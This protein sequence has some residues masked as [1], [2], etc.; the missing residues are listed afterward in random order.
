MAKSSFR[1]TGR[2]RHLVAPSL[3]TAVAAAAVAVW[4]HID[5]ADRRAELMRAAQARAAADVEQTVGRVGETLGSLVPLGLT[6]AESL[7]SGSRSPASLVEEMGAML[8]D[9]PQVY[10]VGLASEP[11]AIDPGTE[12]FS[13][14]FDRKHGEVRHTPS[15]TYDY[16]DAENPDADWYAT[17]L[18]SPGPAWQEPYCDGLSC[19]V[20]YAVPFATPA[21]DPAGVVYINLHPR[22][23]KTLIEDSPL[24]ATGYGMVFSGSGLLVSH[25]ETAWVYEGRTLERLAEDAG[26]DALLGA[27]PDILGG[28][29]GVIEHIDGRSGQASWLFY[30]PIEGTGWAM[31]VVYI[32]DHIRRQH[33][34]LF[35]GQHLAVRMTALGAVFL[36]G[37]FLTLHLQPRFGVRSLWALSALTSVLFVL[38]IAFV[39][40]A[41]LS[42]ARQPLQPPVADPP[43]AD[44]PDAVDAPSPRPVEPRGAA[45]AAPKHLVHR[46][47]VRNHLE[48]YR[49]LAR[50]AGEAPPISLETGV[51]IQSLEFENSYNV[52]ATGYVWQQLEAGRH[53]GVEPG[54]QMPEAISP[55]ITLEYQRPLADDDGDGE[56]DAWLYGWYFEALLR[57][58]FDYSEYP[59]DDKS[60]WIRLWPQELDAP[61]VLTPFFGAYNEIK[62]T[63]LPG[64]EKDFV[65]PGWNLKES[66]FAFRKNQ[67]NVN[68][69]FENRRQPLPELYFHV[70]IRRDFMNA[71]IANL[72]P[73]ISVVL[74]LYTLLLIITYDGVRSERHGFDTAGILGSA[75]A[76]F[77]SVL[78]G[79]VQL[80]D[81][82]QVEEVMYLEYFYF[83]V[84]LLIL[85]V[86]INALLFCSSADDRSL[87]RRYDN[88]FMKLGYWPL[89][90]GALCVVTLWTFT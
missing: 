55:T 69:G 71:F 17:A 85:G 60:V 76:L 1:R 12:A 13:P 31:A 46:A 36:F 49:S 33:D 78:I 65:L 7:E 40:S 48:R 11:F 53:A 32:V 89:I 84:Y 30:R 4:L 51:F 37:L 26:D 86:S 2:S 68:F 52:Y 54:F 6:L 34:A 87:V 20:E 44:P 9:H 90:L 42:G 10:E 73:L 18:S 58:S 16:R 47:A 77:F 59:F 25:P 3:L 27:V 50:A 62:P 14:S 64:L 35:Y 19:Y 15:S 80:R 45:G 8:R 39:W 61:V 74:I 57:Q 24:G 28:G 29:A 88:L 66:Y 38:A 79:H 21:A 5:A 70:D 67:Y 22:D 56:P 43:V 75:A 83:V 72:V 23:L 41:V 82:F 81:Q 63:L